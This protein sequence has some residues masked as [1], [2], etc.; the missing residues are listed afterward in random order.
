MAEHYQAGQLQNPFT[1][2]RKTP[3]ADG[4]GGFTDVE[5]QVG[6]AHFA[7]IRPLRGSERVLNDGLAASVEMMFVT[8]AA[9]DI[10]STDVLLYAGLRYNVRTLNPPGLSKFREV[11]TESGVVS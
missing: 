6:P 5:A 11:L 9:I 3:S 7:A 4:A 1:I 8:W 2:L 10:R